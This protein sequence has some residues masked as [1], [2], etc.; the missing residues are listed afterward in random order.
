M[1]IIN[2]K[3]TEEEKANFRAHPEAMQAIRDEVTRAFID[4]FANILHDKDSPQLAAIHAMCEQNL[5]SSVKDPVLREKLRPNY[6]AAC[7]RLIMSQDFYEA[8]QK[9]NA[10][11]VTEGIER[12]EKSGIRT[13]DDKLHE[14]DV[15]CMATGFR[16]DRF[17]R[18]MQVIG[19][20][21]VVL[22]DVWSKG[23][24]AYLAISIPEFPNLF[25]LNGPN[26][27]VGNFSLIDVAEIQWHYIMQLIDQVRSGRCKEVSP[28]QEATVNFDAERREAAKSTIWMT[29]CKSWYLDAE[30]VPAAWPWTF[31]RFREEMVS[32]KLD[33]YE[34]R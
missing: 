32:P 6:R 26:G 28:T 33:H 1:P 30:G 29:G 24:Y 8:I 12:F 13:S 4:G 7:K 21:G 11:L 22:D 2:P 25:M 15:I 20:D 10:R 9:P 23:P 19:R 5:E 17:M 34:L 16:V 18:P 27:P 3:Y 14:L 31:D